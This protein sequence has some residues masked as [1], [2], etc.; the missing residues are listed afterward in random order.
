M[1]NLL[2]VVQTQ[3][4]GKP[5]KYHNAFDKRHDARMV[6][7]VIKKHNVNSRIRRY[8]DAGKG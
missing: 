7:Y 5:W 8:V 2:W 1:K 6:A 3:H 4:Q